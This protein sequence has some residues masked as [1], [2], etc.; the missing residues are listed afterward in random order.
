MR[1][2]QIPLFKHVVTTTQ[3]KGR[4]G[5]GGWLSTATDGD[6]NSPSGLGSATLWRVGRIRS[7]C[8]LEA[9]AAQRDVR[10]GC[11]IG[12]GERWRKQPNDRWGEVDGAWVVSWWSV[13]EMTAA[14]SSGCRIRTSS[15]TDEVEVDD[16]DHCPPAHGLYTRL[17]GKPLT[18]QRRV[19]P[20]RSW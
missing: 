19:V 7:A 5:N 9:H 6:D 12:L 1:N 14:D 15:D 3:S 11:D 2:D 18:R 16:R 17:A 20:R 10:R 4:S 13:V 8:D